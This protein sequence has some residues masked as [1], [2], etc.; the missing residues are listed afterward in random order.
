M[1]SQGRFGITLQK[2]LYLRFH[3]EYTNDAVLE[4][5]QIVSFFQDPAPTT[6]PGKKGTAKDLWD[7]KTITPEKWIEKCKMN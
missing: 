4:V 5:C 6:E 1:I 2:S 7:I 3:L